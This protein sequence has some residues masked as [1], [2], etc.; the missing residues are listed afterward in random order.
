MD[1]PRIIKKYPNRRLY[2]TGISRYI[3]LDDV[4]KLVVKGVPFCILDAKTDEDLTRNIL[5]QI[6]LEQEE[7][8]EPLF[9]SR[10]LEQLIRLY[11]DSLQ[12]SIGNYLEK[13]FELMSEQQARMHEQMQSMMDP[14]AFMLDAAEKNLNF[15]KE[16][17]ESFFKVMINGPGSYSRPG[18][19]DRT[20][21]S[22][23]KASE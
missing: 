23:D 4:K 18:D 6:I 7:K 22:S 1:E 15:W 10:M 2:D 5:L 19:K 17:Q 3:T 9:S 13:S 14:L 21:S 12:G 11:G 8:G 20:P 16:M